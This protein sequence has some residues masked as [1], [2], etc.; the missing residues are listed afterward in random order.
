MEWD[1][2]LRVIQSPNQDELIQLEIN[3][4]TIDILKTLL[5][6]KIKK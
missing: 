2:A 4:L 6:L 5:Y 1:P 3:N